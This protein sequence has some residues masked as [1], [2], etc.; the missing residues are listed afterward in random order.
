MKYIFYFA[1]VFAFVYSVLAFTGT[2]SVPPV[3]AGV[4][5]ITIGCTMILEGLR[6]EIR[7]IKKERRND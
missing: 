7:R 6:F 5:W 3:I 4:M 2:Y 1:G